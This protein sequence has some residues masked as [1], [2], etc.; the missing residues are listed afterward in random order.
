MRQE[1][2]PAAFMYS[3]V[4]RCRRDTACRVSEVRIFHLPPQLCCSSL[5][6][7]RD[8]FVTLHKQ[9]VG[10]TKVPPTVLLSTVLI[11]QPWAF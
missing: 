9:I 6:T 7:K 11:T 3:R 5:L 4:R 8:S 1:S 10:E 2:F